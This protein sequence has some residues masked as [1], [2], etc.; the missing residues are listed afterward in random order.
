MIYNKFNIGDELVSLSSRGYKKSFSREVL[1]KSFVVS[2]IMWNGEIVTYEDKETK[3]VLSERELRENF[4][5]V[6]K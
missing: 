5:I 3:I 4:K 1:C 6:N 2:N